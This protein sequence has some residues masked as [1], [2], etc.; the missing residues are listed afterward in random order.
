MEAS[1]CK[2]RGNFTALGI[3]KVK[4]LRPRLTAARVSSPGPPMYILPRGYCTYL[5]HDRQCRAVCQES[6]Q[7]GMRNISP[8]LD[9]IHCV[10]YSTVF[11]FFFFCFFLLHTDKD[12]IYC[13]VIESLDRAQE[14]FRGRCEFHPMARKK[15][16][17]REIVFFPV[18][19]KMI[20]VVRL[21]TDS[22]N[23]TV[24]F[25]DFFFI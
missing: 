14:Q 11:F 21:L 3:S 12:Y 15:S 8:P 17:W 22:A 24:L 18:R 5:S 19:T 2:S 13:T 4:R 7:C 10:V 9:T 6:Y 23:R 25:I 1:G 20:T 16:F